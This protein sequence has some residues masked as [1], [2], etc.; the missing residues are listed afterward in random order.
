[1]YGL[2]REGTTVPLS[3]A[4]LSHRSTFTVVSWALR[5]VWGGYLNDLKWSRVESFGLLLNFVLHCLVDLLP[6]KWKSH[7]I[8][9]YLCK[10]GQN[11]SQ[12][13]AIC[14]ISL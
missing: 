11:M 1:M 10:T 5:G 8:V 13:S 9:C 4:M 12:H 2:T 3:A 6:H 7:S 14:T